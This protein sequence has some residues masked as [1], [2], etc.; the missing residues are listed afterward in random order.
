MEAELREAALAAARKSWVNI[1][2]AAKRKF[3]A[4]KARPGLAD[5]Q[6]ASRGL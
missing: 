2:R 6:A 1:A 3:P 4:K 5:Q